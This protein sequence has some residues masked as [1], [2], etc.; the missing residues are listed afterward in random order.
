MLRVNIQDPNLTLRIGQ[1]TG[2]GGYP[3]IMD[4]FLLE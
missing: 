2:G 1:P 3:Y 4:N